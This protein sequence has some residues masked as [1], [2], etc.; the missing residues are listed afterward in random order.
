[1]A[2]GSTITPSTYDLDSQALRVAN[3]LMGETFAAFADAAT[4]QT[5]IQRS[6]IIHLSVH[7]ASMISVTN[8]KAD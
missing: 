3:T 7:G 6:P 8:A 4:L 1:M 5:N 2:T